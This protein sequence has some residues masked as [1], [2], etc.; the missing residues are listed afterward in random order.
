MIFLSKI[1]YSKYCEV[2]KI[3]K[4]N[5]VAAYTNRNV[6]YLLQD[7]NSPCTFLTVSSDTGIA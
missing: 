7:I 6:S 5:S 4:R 3:K 1:L 2:L